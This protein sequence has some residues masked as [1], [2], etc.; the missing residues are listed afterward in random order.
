MEGNDGSWFDYVRTADKHT[1]ERKRHERNKKMDVPFSLDGLTAEERTLALPYYE[2]MQP[3][4]SVPLY[5]HQLPRSGLRWIDEGDRKTSVE[6]HTCGNVHY[7]QRK[8]L[9]NEM[10]FLALEG[11]Q[12]KRYRSIRS[13]NEKSKA[14]AWLS[15]LRG[16]GG[17]MDGGDI[18]VPKSTDVPIVV[19]AGAGGTGQ[20]L[21]FLC[22]LFQGV[23][24][25]CYDMSEYDAN[26]RDEV[27]AGRYPN[28]FLHES[29]FGDEQ[30][31]AFAYMSR[32]SGHSVYLISDIRSAGKQMSFEAFEDRVHEDNEMQYDWV[33]RI[34]PVKAHLKWRLPYTRTEA[35]IVKPCEFMLQPWAGSE[36]GEMRQVIDRPHGNEPYR[37]TSMTIDEFENRMM[38]L[39]SA[40]KPY[41]C[42]ESPL[43]C[44]GYYPYDEVEV[45]LEE[46]L[47]NVGLG[48]DRCWN[49]TYEI[50]C[51]CVYL[52]F[53]RSRIDEPGA[54]KA[55]LEKHKARVLL[56]FNQNTM[57]NCRSLNINC[58]GL[59]P[60]KTAKE[61]H[62]W[63]SE[64]NWRERSRFD[65]RKM[66]KRKGSGEGRLD[67]LDYCPY[68]HATKGDSFFND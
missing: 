20:H 32:E 47:D 65:V 5:L 53:E 21:L 44:S 52:G 31:D 38:V 40:V 13:S 24:F 39:R 8:L 46:S 35:R 68:E 7:G 60:D 45:R 25:H 22:K 55:F 3:L 2:A 26:L 57:V 42:Y 37:Y 27:E 29:L 58:H 43:P 41:A 33:E 54:L 63:F 67:Q 49:C 9:L 11:L 17:D 62:E 30:C 34:R 23:C 19:Y 4:E 12:S 59:L 10:L 36:S 66:Q 14:F 50:V 1:T 28:L 6:F 64:G 15:A 48:M 18:R 61:K 56:F 51:W 16:A